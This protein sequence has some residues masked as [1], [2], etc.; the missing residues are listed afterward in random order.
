MLMGLAFYLM[1]CAGTGKML[2]EKSL[3][4]RKRWALI[5]AAIGLVV[6]VALGGFN[7]FVIGVALIVCY[8]GFI[9]TVHRPK[10]IVGTKY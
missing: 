10:W 5:E 9:T 6:I 1:A 8:L 3:E 2:A 4:V 7:Y